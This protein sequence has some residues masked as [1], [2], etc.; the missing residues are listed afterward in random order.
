MGRPKLVLSDEQRIYLT[1]LAIES[2]GKFSADVVRDFNG[3]FCDVKPLAKSTLQHRFDEIWASI[4]HHFQAD[5][6]IC[7][8]FFSIHGAMYFRSSI[9]IKRHHNL[10]SSEQFVNMQHQ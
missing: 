9:N 5:I 6:G 3:K 10:S 8:C 7:F 2:K 1:E 4:G